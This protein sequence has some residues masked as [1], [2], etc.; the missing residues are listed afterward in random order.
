MTELL[1][2]PKM[3]MKM[4]DEVRAIT[5]NKKDIKLD[6]LDEMHYLNAVIKETLRLHPILPLLVPR[7]SRREAKIQGY[8][9]AAGTQVFINVWAIGRDPG[10]WDSPEEFHPERFLNS[11]IDFKGHDFQLIPFGAGRR[12]CPG[13]S[14]AITNIKLVLAKFVNYFDWKLPNGAKGED[15]DMTESIGLS[16]HKKFPLIAVATPYVA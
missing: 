2:H 1:R 7:E 10:L 14:F 13:I 3:M 16:I 5:S 15:L 4:Q 9:I 11:S 12:S 6:D 8:D